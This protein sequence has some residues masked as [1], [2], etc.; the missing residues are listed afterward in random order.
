MLNIIGILK[1]NEILSF[2]IIYMGLEGNML[3]KQTSDR[4]RHSDHTIWS[5]Y[6]ESKTRQMNKYS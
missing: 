1:Q 4:E 5:P 2:A 3:S 6:V